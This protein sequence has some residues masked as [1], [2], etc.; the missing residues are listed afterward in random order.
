MAL[1]EID[2][3][4]FKFKHLLIAEK[5]ATLTLKSV[6]GRAQVT[7][8]VDLGHL[9]SRPGHPH[10]HA[11]NGTSRSRRQERRAAARKQAAEE[12]EKSP[13]NVDEVSEPVEKA[14][15]KVNTT[16]KVAV[17]EEVTD[18]F[19]SNTEY[20]ENER[21]EIFSFKSDF[22]EEDIERCLDEI[23]TNTKIT[24]T[25]IIHRDQLG[26]ENSVYLYTLELKIEEG[27]GQKTSFSWPQ[28]S[29]AQMKVFQ[30]LKRIF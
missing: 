25:K 30:N 22:A 19:C 14:N 16:A 27:K 6:A 2:S 12:A 18:E 23:F 17:T 26:P 10:H 4:F 7:L 9:H 11:S 29:P 24:S 3:F 8:S 13:E 20:S 21:K 15:D 1:S 5:D 28:M